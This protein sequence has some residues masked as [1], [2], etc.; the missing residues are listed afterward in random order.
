MVHFICSGITTHSV[1]AALRCATLRYGLDAWILFQ[2][3]AEIFSFPLHLHPSLDPTHP[4]SYPTG[5]EDS[6]SRGYSGE[7]NNA[8]SYTYTFLYTSMVVLN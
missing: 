4:A 3:E 5:T 6:F 1:D 8:W 2:A 7:V